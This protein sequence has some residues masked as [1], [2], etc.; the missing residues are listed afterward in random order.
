MPFTKLVEFGLYH[1]QIKLIWIYCCYL[2][3]F[4]FSLYY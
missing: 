4:L 1:P 2:W 3:Y